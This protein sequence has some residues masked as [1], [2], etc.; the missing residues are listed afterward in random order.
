MTWKGAI[1]DP[2]AGTGGFLV[3]ILKAGVPYSS[4]TALEIDERLAWVGGMNLFAHGATKAQAH[5]LPQ[6]GTL[7]RDGERF[8]NSFDAIIT[9][10]P[11][12]SDFSDPDLLPK[13]QLGGNRTSRRRGIL[14][15]ERCHQL[16]RPGGMLALIIDEGVL[17][18]ASAEDVRRFVTDNFTVHAIVSLPEGAF[19]PY[20]TVNASILFLQKARR[21]K[22]ESVPTFFARAEKVGRKANGDDDYIYDDN[23]AGHPNSDLPDIVRLFRSFQRTGTLRPSELAYEA[24]IAENFREEANGWRLDFRYHH[25]SRKYSR[26]LLAR[27]QSRLMP[28]SD[29]CQERNQTLIP[30]TELADQIILYTGLAQI[31]AGA[32]VAHQVPTPSNSLKSAVKRYEPGD[33]IFAKMRPNLRKAAL[34]EFN[35]GGYVSAECIV[36]TVKQRDGHP[37]IDPLLLS[38]LLRSDLVYGQ[39]MHLIAGIGRPRLSAGDLRR[40]LIPSANY[41]AQQSWRSRYLS[42]ITVAQKLKEKADQ[43]LRDAAAM[44]RS[45]VERLARSLFR[46]GCSANTRVPGRTTRTESNS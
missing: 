43:L 30:S 25:P 26:T 2:A 42:D 45:A 11:F 3:Q 8:L 9:N 22:P 29:I 33:I 38:I 13:Y 32:G 36:L 20:A 41:A 46:R 37:I 17:N 27:A 10:P 16:L 44:E 28:L 39:I 24:D 12:G 7:G 19:M 4:L 5:W 15:L 40:V 23:G 1:C 35:E 21:N 31:E 6:G 18:L 34:M 14:F